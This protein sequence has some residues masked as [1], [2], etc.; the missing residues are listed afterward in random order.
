MRASWSPSRF[1]E[2]GGT[3][4][5]CA[6][7]CWGLL[8][9][10]SRW[11]KRPPDCSTTA[12]AAAGPCSRASSSTSPSALAYPSRERSLDP[13]DLTT[14]SKV[15]PACSNHAVRRAS[16]AP[17][18]AARGAGPTPSIT[19]LWNADHASI[20][21]RANSDCANEST[22][23]ARGLEW[24]SN[25]GRPFEFGAMTLNP[26]SI[27]MLPNALSMRHS[28]SLHPNILGASKAAA[29][30][31]SAVLTHR[32]DSIVMPTF[33]VSFPSSPSCAAASTSVNSSRRAA[34]RSLCASLRNVR[35]FSEKGLSLSSCSSLAPFKNACSAFSSTLATLSRT[36]FT[37]LS[38]AR[39]SDSSC[40][41]GGAATHRSRTKVRRSGRCAGSPHSAGGRVSK[42]TG[43][44]RLRPC[45]AADTRSM[46]A[47]CE[48]LLYDRAQ[49][50]NPSAYIATL[51]RQPPIRQSTQR[52]KPATA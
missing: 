7:V 23:R 52:I 42:S 2:G 35:R 18:P 41:N 10:S 36:S 33:P 14:R 34:A 47:H 16:L 24:T 40:G 31:T 13:D 48:S 20:I 12:R 19:S 15:L 6:G 28:A 21:S 39:V 1:V 37:S 22:A 9:E 38:K 30:R 46:R 17:P 51:L 3:T 29:A 8:L 4:Q 27:S 50:I 26:R 43:P 32:C 11:S 25:S 49:R 44:T 5:V 45:V